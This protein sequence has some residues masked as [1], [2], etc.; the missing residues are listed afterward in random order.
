MSFAAW[1]LI[2]YMVIINAYAVYITMQDKKI[3]IHNGKGLKAKR[4]VP[5]RNLLTVAAMGGSI[6]MLATM[7]K[8]RH[9]TQHSKFMVGIPLIIAA[10]LALVILLIIVF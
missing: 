8:I 4:R 7:F 9:K 6:A 3:A 2:I 1:L 5:E 10:Q